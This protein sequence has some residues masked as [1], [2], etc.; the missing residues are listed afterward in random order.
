MAVREDPVGATPG[1]PVVLS[2]A[3]PGSY[4]AKG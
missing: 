2:R 1:V 4:V 3:A